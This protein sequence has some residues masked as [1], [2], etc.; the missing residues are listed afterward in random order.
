MI[1]RSR[2]LKSLLYDRKQIEASLKFAKMKIQLY[3]R[4]FEG[5]DIE[6]FDMVE[7]RFCIEPKA[8][9]AKEKLLAKIKKLKG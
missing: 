7:K 4:V 1:Y 6:A 5:D 2:Y 8:L 3:H 9:S